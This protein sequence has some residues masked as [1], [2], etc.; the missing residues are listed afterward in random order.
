VAG[1]DEPLALYYVN[2]DGEK[3]QYVLAKSNIKV[4]TYAAPE[5][6]NTTFEKYLTEVK[7]TGGAMNQQK[8]EVNGKEE[9][10][11]DVEVDGQ[12]IPM[13]LISQTTVGEFI[14]PQNPENKIYQNVRLSEPVETIGSHPEN[15]VEVIE[16]NNM[17]RALTNTTLV[18]ILV[19]LGQLITS[20][21]GGYA[22]ARL[23]FPGRDTVFV[24]YLG[25]IMIPFVMLIVPLYQLMVVIG[26]TDRLAALIIPWIFTAYGTFLMRQHFI[27]FPKEIE[28]AAILDGASHGQILTQILIPASVPALATQATFTFLY[29]WN[30][31]IWPLVIINVGNEKNHVLTLALNVLRGRASDTPNLILAG[32]AIAII[33]PLIVFIIGQRFFVES[34][35]SSGVKG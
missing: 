34:V 1:Y 14:D 22:F 17:A 11:F 23:K 9:K 25:T 4:G 30:S 27:T 21:V 32:A 6:L 8:V 2:V 31:F 3:L 29:A 15:Y 7:P 12:I 26:W 10:L 35:A 19:V 20:V 16:L 13:I 5:N 24:F 28:E 18:T 33:P